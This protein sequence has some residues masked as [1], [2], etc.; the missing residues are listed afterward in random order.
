MSNFAWAAAS[1]VLS[2]RQDHDQLQALQ[3]AYLYSYLYSTGQVYGAAGGG[4]QP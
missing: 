3:N 4:G 2:A 1:S